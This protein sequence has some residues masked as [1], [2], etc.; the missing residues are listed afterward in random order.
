MA[1]SITELVKKV[2]DVNG[3]SFEQ[4]AQSIGYSEQDLQKEIEKG[5]DPSIVELLF[6][7]HPNSLRGIPR[8]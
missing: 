3:L 4:V 1:A 8:D 6:T 5:N 2:Q 7:K